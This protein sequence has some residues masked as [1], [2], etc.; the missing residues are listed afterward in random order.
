MDRKR[1]QQLVDNTQQNSLEFLT[2]SDSSSMHV[3]PFTPMIQ[4]KFV[5]EAMAKGD[6]HSDTSFSVGSLKAARRAAGAVQ[7]AVDR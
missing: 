6:G 4:K 7:Y 1:K 3:V 5:K 2:A